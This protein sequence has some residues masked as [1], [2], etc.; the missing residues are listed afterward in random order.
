MLEKY[1]DRLK[2]IY[3]DM[4]N[5]EDIRKKIFKEFIGLKPIACFVNNAAISYD[6]IVTNLNYKPLLEMYNINVFGPMMFT[7]YVIRQF[8]I[9]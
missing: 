3:Y 2:W 4:S 8:F 7:K 9:A 1:P 6:D 5:I